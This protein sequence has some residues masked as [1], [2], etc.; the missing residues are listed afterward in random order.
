MRRSLAL[1]IAAGLALSLAS[2]A[3]AQKIDKNGR[4]HDA[5]G[6]FAKAAVCKGAAAPAGTA[7][8]SPAAAEPPAKITRCRD[9]TTQKYVK[10]GTPNAVAADAKGR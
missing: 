2:G 10:C 6:K 7:S 9:A 5:S 8:V 3:S 1:I 4:C